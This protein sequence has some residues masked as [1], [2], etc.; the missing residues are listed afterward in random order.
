MNEDVTQAIRV[1]EGEFLSCRY[2]R[3]KGDGTATLQWLT[4]TAVFVTIELAG[5]GPEKNFRR[6]W[7][8]KP[9]AAEKIQQMFSG[10]EELPHSG[11]DGFALHLFR[12]GDRVA[13][14]EWSAEDEPETLQRLRALLERAGHLDC[15]EAMACWHR[16]HAFA[17]GTAYSQAIEAFRRGIN[18]LGDAYRNQELID[19]TAMRLALAES[20]EKTGE[21]ELARTL[22]ER[23]LQ[24]RINEYL[25]THRLAS[26]AQQ[27]EK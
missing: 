24:S 17:E 8:G 26:D 14:L 19:D 21:M 16:G 20:S 11:G 9:A 4:P 5:E 23:A 27:W 6:T 12:K 15:A 25:I 22:F 2:L 3:K 13:T 1:E 7:N 10:I 18:G